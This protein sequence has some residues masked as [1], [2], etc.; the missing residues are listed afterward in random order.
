MATKEPVKLVEVAESAGVSIATASNALSNKG[1][2][3][4][5]TRLRVQ[6][7][8]TKLGYRANPTA[9]T[10]RAG[11]KRLAGFVLPTVE[12]QFGT[13]SP[14]LFWSKLLESLAQHV[15]DIGFGL[16]VVSSEHA[17]LLSSLPIEAA[18]S[19][20]EVADR[21]LMKH[22]LAWG[23]PIISSAPIDD[24]RVRGTNSINHDQATRDVLN[25]LAKNG[26]KRPAL[27]LMKSKAHYIMTARLAFED[28][29]N[30]KDVTAT[31][32]ECSADAQATRQA[33]EDA[34]RAGIDGVY[35]LT[36]H[37][38]AALDGIRAAGKRIPQDILVVAQAE[39]LVEAEL[40]PPVSNLS[41]QPAL[42]GKIA[43]ETLEAVMASKRRIQHTVPHKLVVRESSQR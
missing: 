35:L 2:I 28:W 3:S 29:C 31:V 12:G 20:D 22:G 16:V 8:A 5:P 25:H 7:A 11:R 1:R 6:K 41:F 9:R 4:E 36:G 42:L 24:P 14:N 18:F 37:S 43:A 38:P 40:D 21:E 17:D 27:V 19:S 15:S 10:L 34:A 30:K 26:C 23:V 39:G 13:D 33:T 32:F